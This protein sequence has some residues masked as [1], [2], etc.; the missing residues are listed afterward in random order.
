MWQRQEGT[1]DGDVYTSQLQ[2][3]QHDLG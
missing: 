1:K 2:L 3:K